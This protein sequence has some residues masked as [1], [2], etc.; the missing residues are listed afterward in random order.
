LR[1]A[2][3]Q[4]ESTNTIRKPRKRTCTWV[5]HPGAFVEVELLA[6]PGEPVLPATA[7]DRRSAVLAF[8]R[9]HRCDSRVSMADT[10]LLLKVGQQRCQVRIT[11]PT[12]D[13]AALPG[14]ID[15]PH[16]RHA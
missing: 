3:I 6:E 4:I 15:Q 2:R 9:P 11:R 1:Y 8:S 14:L 7:T 16:M 5:S 10:A 12:T 13:C